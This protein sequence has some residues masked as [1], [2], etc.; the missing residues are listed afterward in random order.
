MKSGHCSRPPVRKMKVRH[1][2][3]AEV[4]ARQVS[5]HDAARYR[6]H[7]AVAVPAEIGEVDSPPV[8][9]GYRSDELAPARADIEDPFR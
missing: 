3:P 6:L 4:A 9:G 8:D 2:H 1:D 5:V 7:R